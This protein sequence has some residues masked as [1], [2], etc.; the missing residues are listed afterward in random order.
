MERSFDDG[1]TGSPPSPEGVEGYAAAF[2]SCLLDPAREAPD[3]IAAPGGGRAA[4]RFAVY[5]NNVAASLVNAL[6]D[7]YPAVAK[8]VGEEFFRAMALVFAR[9]S[10]PR[11][12]VLSEYG[13]DFPDLIA[14]F[15]PAARMPYLAD[16]ARLERAWLDAF[17]AADAQPLDARELGELAPDELASA[18]FVPHPAMRLVRSRYAAI[19]IMEANRGNGGSAGRIRGDVGEDALVT[20]PGTNVEVRRLPPGCAGFLQGLAAGA[21]LAAA[22]ESAL[23]EQ[24][25]FDAGGAIALMIEAG[26]FSALRPNR[27][28][29]T[30]SA[31]TGG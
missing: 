2:A 17:H 18:C 11:S 14:D 13:H 9:S 5:R 12:R 16:V 7:I 3:S 10:P 30:Q 6:A 20:R 19:S 27:A 25:V 26:A 31:G 1:L 23:E 29:A 8:I 28:I 4:K 24:P 21:S 22:V 15:G